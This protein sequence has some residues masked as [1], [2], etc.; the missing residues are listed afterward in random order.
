MRKPEQRLYDS[1]KANRPATHT[2]ILERIENMTGTGTPDVH[3]TRK[4]AG[5]GERAVTSWIELKVIKLPVRLTSKVFKK[6]RM[7]VAQTAWHVAYAS[8]GGR[9]FIFARD[10]RR[11]LYLFPGA[12][13]ER[14]PLM[15]AHEVLQ[16]RIA[17]WAV[18]YEETFA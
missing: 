18:L 8:I 9:S 7:R 11:K 13:A 16:Y 5:K 17:S 2:I 4:A 15:T 14:L 3:A 6:D 1:M 10:Q 12:H